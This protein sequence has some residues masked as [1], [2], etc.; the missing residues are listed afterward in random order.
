[1]STSEA[2]C[3]IKL[4]GTSFSTVTT[5]PLR[6][7]LGP[8][9]PSPQRLAGDR[10]VFPLGS[11]AQPCTKEISGFKAPTAPISCPL[12]KGSEIMRK[13]SL[14]SSAMLLPAMDRVGRKDM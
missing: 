5:T 2:C 10:I 14:F 11:A 4:I 13:E 6:L 9:A 3:R 12:P 7:A 8:Q 1:M